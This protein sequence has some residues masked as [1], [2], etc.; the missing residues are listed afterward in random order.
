M[1]H[2]VARQYVEQLLLP[3]WTRFKN[4]VEPARRSRLRLVLLWD[5]APGH[6]KYM[7]CG[8]GNARL[9]NAEAGVAL[10]GRECTSYFL[11]RLYHK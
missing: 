11:F 8:S 5:H 1:S 3:A 2:R 4:S 7:G 9:L 10:I 6:V